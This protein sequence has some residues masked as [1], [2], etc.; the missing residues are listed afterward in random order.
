MA[1]RGRGPRSWPGHGQGQ[2]P[3][4]PMWCRWSRRRRLPVG[5]CFRRW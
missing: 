2:R 5:R 3:G 1:S 4:S